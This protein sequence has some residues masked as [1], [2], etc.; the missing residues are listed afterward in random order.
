VRETYLLSHHVKIDSK[1]SGDFNSGF[2]TQ[3]ERWLA[4]CRSVL[5][6]AS[7]VSH[8]QR[9]L[10]RHSSLVDTSSMAIPSCR[11]PT[12]VSKTYGAPPLK[13]EASSPGLVINKR[14]STHKRRAPTLASQMR[15]DYDNLSQSALL[16]LFCLP[17]ARQPESRGSAW[18]RQWA[19][20]KVKVTRPLLKCQTS[21]GWASSAK[22]KHSHPR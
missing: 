20:S 10:S 9:P 19:L 12:D 18:G 22:G 14:N 1:C 8:R 15:F 13:L 6:I 5:V 11:A 21:V 7:L 3:I 17:R 4:R 16:H 2:S